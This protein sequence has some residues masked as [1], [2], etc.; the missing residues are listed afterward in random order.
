[1][2]QSAEEIRRLEAVLE[3]EPASYVFAAL[4]ELYLLS[5][6]PEQATATARRGTE[7]HPEYVAGQLAL[8][9]ALAAV[10]ES[11]DARA[12]LER[13]V[14]AVP[15]KPEAQKLLARL[16]LDMNR[17]DLADRTL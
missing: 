17:A 9:K 10:G 3:A 1:M 11:G 12:I 13:V 15:E 8:A 2:E 14:K 4:S 16:Y 5:G 7:L 6:R